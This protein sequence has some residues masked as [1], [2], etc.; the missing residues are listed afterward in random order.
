[1]GTS[2][3]LP[4]SVIRGV[5]ARHT[6]FVVSAGAQAP[7]RGVTSS[8]EVLPGSKVRLTVTVPVEK[9]KA[10]YRSTLQNWNNKIACTGFRKGKAPE[11]VLIKEL[12]GQQRVYNTVI[13][14]LI[15]DVL[16]G[17]LE[18]TPS[19]GR[20]IAESE[21]IEQTGE[22]LENAF[23]PS[24]DFTFSVMF[25]TLPELSWK[26]PYTS[27]AI[28]VAAVSS[29]DADKAKADAKLR[30]LQKERGGQMRVVNGRGVQRGDMAIVDFDAAVEETGEAIPGAARQGMQL[31]T[32]TADEAFLPG[33]VEAM[34]GMIAGEE[35][36]TTITFP[37][38]EDFSPA[39]LRGVTAAV[40]IKVSE[41]FEWEMP[42][43]N[44]E[45]AASVM[46]PRST[47]ADV[48]TRLIENTRAESEEALQQCIADAF[49]E[50]VAN[51]VSVE[52]P[53]SLIQEAGQNEYSRELNQLITKGVLAYEQA[54]KLATPQLVAG[55]IQRKRGDIE[56]LQ[57]SA[58]GF[59]DILRR[60][61][62][63]PSE[64]AIEDELYRALESVRESQGGRG[65]INEDGV[66]AQVIQTLEY[67]AVMDWLVA[68]CEVN[69]KPYAA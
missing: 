34:M 18:A 35:R 42:E 26:T 53:D 19:A 20:A 13:A 37:D 60:E 23:N 43:E 41:V 47:I 62:I 69:V 67:Q 10:A 64:A 12:G 63:A 66:K 52:I 55:Y 61:G 24:K 21:R 46:G 57:R 50:A 7:P 48:R 6:V 29:E 51:A 31:D 14:D 45:W 25:D 68:N 40:T 11:D 8:E 16:A 33:V 44:D 27:L 54:E 32:D 17:A 38:S 36:K 58:L 9:C 59:S 4:R 49:T 28:T 3:A 5:T 22:E 1:L 65:D 2:A 30:T 56:N 39:A 15:E